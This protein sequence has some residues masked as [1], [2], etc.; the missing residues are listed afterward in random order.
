VYSPFSVSDIVRCIRDRLDSDPTLQ[1]VWVQAEVSNWFQSRA[2]HCYF[3]LKDACATLRAVMWRTIAERQQALPQDGQLVLAH[4]HVSVYEPQGQVQFYVDSLLP[5]G[6]GTLYVRFEELKRRLAAE[7]LFDTE[8]K[9]SL[10]ETPC[11][12]GVVTSAQGAAFQDICNVLSRRWP[13]VRVI[14]SPTLVQGD[15]APVQIVAALRALYRRDDVDLIIVAR[16]GG[17]IEDLWAFNDEGVAHAIAASPVPVVT[18]IGH[19]IDTTISD[20]AADRRAPTPSAAAELAVPDQMEVR[21]RLA[22]MRAALADAA[23]RR[24]G[25]AQRV[26]E[27]H[28]RAL[29]RVSPI[30]RIARERQTIDDLYLRLGR[31]IEHRVDLLRAQM[32]TVQQRLLGLDPTAVLKRG[33]AV[34]RTPDGTIVRRVAQ[35]SEGDAISVRV[36]DGVFGARVE[37]T[38]C[39][40]EVGICPN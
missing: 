26:I 15:E 35:V 14:L 9:R 33:Y 22:E 2:G 34:V 5:T 31:A 30:L 6:L 3:T 40:P 1:D 18:G 38:S 25:E 10:P 11:C 16:G 23:L 7:G 4:G 13:L 17:S 8:R 36:S 19:E 37:A 24:L 20:L 29:T 12:I 27:D 28:A 21:S 32:E 39:S